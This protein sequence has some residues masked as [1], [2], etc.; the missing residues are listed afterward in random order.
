[1]ASAGPGIGQVLEACAPGQAP[2]A[3][4]PWPAPAAAIL[5]LWPDIF[6]NN[7]G[8][9]CEYE[10]FNGDMDIAWCVGI[11]FHCGVTSRT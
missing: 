2:S 7:D 10:L 4:S 3:I 11:G 9:M 1:M 5:L 6:G 8:V